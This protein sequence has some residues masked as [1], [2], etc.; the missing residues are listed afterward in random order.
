[1]KADQEFW[2]WLW[3]DDD[4]ESAPPPLRQGPQTALEGV[5][6]GRQGEAGGRAEQAA[7]EPSRVRRSTRRRTARRARFLTVLGV[8]VAAGAVVTAAVLAS[9]VSDPS[10]GPGFGS[11]PARGDQRVI[12]WTVWDD[13]VREKPFV[14]VLATGGGREPIAVAV[15]GNTVVSIPG[16]SL[17][18]VD[19]AAD[20]GDVAVVA[21][22]VE[23]ILGVQVDDGW[24]IDMGTLRRLVDGLGGIRAGFEDLD[25]AG[26]AAY[27]RDS[28]PIERPIRWQEVLGGVLEAIGE[29]PNVLEELPEELIPPGDIRPVFGAGSRDVL[30]LP[31]EDVGAG[32]ADLDEAAVQDLVTERFVPTGSEEKVR[33]VVLN[34]NGTPGIGTDVARLLVPEGFRLVASTNADAFD[35]ERT[36][37]VASSVD[38]L[39]DARRAQRLLGVGEVLLGRPSGLADVLVVVG[40]DF[41]VDDPGGP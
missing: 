9:R 39:D 38:F 37:V 32:L 18:T 27:L 15:P 1:V 22:T 26:T 21:A 23:N 28:P 34:G 6:P 12:A 20:D 10:T 19:E 3:E 31:V 24:G 41:A 16:R 4:D 29:D 13:Q 7:T 33:L 30:M 35:Q 17:G 25:G 2:D 5:P 8:L 14:A 36:V 40:K 11:V